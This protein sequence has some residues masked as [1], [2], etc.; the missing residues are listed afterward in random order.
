MPLASTDS[1]MIVTRS[2]STDMKPPSIWA[3][4]HEPSS[5]HTHLTLTEDAQQ[6]LVTR[7]DAQVALGGART[8]LARLAL[9]DLAVGGDELDLERHQRFFWI[10]A[11]WRSTSSRPPHMK[12]ACSPTWS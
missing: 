2:W 4:R 6:G 11:H 5:V 1:A 7:E 9:P 3:D 10:S 8:D 12:N